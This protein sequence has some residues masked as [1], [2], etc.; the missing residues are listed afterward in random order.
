M[1]T[2]AETDCS[3]RALALGRSAGDQ[4]AELGLALRSPLP[5]VAGATCQTQQS[6]CLS[7]V[8]TLAGLDCPR[9]VVQVADLIDRAQRVSLRLNPSRLTDSPAVRAVR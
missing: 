6:A 3:G 9:K 4:Q 1:Q 2:A 7:Q 5:V 8:S